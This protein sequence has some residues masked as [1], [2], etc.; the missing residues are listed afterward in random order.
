MPQAIIS[1]IMSCDNHVISRYLVET[2]ALQAALGDG[3]VDES[4]PRA[5]VG[6]NSTWRGRRK[7]GNETA[8][9]C[10]HYGSHYV[11][12]CHTLVSRVYGD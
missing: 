1:C 3:E 12:H 10:C 9:M 5:E 7:V 8:I 2:L 11:T 4:H 6:G